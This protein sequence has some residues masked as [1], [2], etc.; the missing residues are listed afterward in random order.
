MVHTSSAILNSCSFQIY[1]VSFQNLYSIEQTQA[2][3]ISH[4]L[5]FE[6]NYTYFIISEMNKEKYQQNDRDSDEEFTLTD[7]D[8]RKSI[9]KI[10]TLHGKELPILRVR[11][12]LEAE[13]DTQWQ[14]DKRMRNKIRKMWMDINE[15]D[16][17]SENIE[18]K[19]K[20]GIITKN[21]TNNERKIGIE[22]FVA[23]EKDNPPTKQMMNTR[24]KE[25][26]HPKQEKQIKKMQLKNTK[27][28][29]SYNQD[30]RG[31]I[32]GPYEYVAII[33]YIESKLKNGVIFKKT[34]IYNECKFRKIFS[35]SM[36]LK[37][38]IQVLFSSERV[39]KMNGTIGGLTTQ[40]WL[41]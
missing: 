26:N 33:D 25:K 6:N 31:K 41:S 38:T 12:L 27:L 35:K 19:S 10:R 17:Q 40:L 8:L 21:S 13:W 39:W 22:D 37:T 3:L 36:L 18:W 28:D 7:V 24:E 4:L 32:W 30:G 1:S 14:D 34:V 9:I 29:S 20:E 11:N 5:A 15:Y 2:L 16:F 23:E